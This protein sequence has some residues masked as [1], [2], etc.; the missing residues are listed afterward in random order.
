MPDTYRNL[1][2]AA[3]CKATL[4]LAASLFRALRKTDLTEVFKSYTSQT[5]QYFFCK[6]CVVS[7]DLVEKEDVNKIASNVQ[8]VAVVALHSKE[9]Y[10]RLNA[11]TGDGSAH[12]LDILA[13]FL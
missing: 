9:K 2:S 12:M 5:T 13:L 10:R 8:Q 3:Y 6:S 1:L 11:W 7:R 4:I